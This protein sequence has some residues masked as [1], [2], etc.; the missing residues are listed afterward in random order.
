MIFYVVILNSVLPGFFPPSINIV[1]PQHRSLAS[2]FRWKKYLAKTMAE[3]EQKKQLG[4]KGHMG[5]RH[6]VDGRH[7]ALVE[8]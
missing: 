2:E 3:E 1:A 6:T 5:K 4:N 7:P 8:K